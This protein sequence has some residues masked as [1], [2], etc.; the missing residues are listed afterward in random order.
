MQEFKH[1]ISPSV[2]PI[3][4]MVITALTSLVIIDY[5]FIRI[6]SKEGGGRREEGGGR[7]EEGGGRREEGG[8]RREEGGGRREEGGGRREEGGGRREEGGGKGERG[9]EED[10][11]RTFWLQELKKIPP[12]SCHLYIY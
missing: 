11:F 9:S 4:T 1:I 12:Q 8:G 3:A 6:R 5:P 7:R 10:F 2:P